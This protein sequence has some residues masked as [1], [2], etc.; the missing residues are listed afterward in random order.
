MVGTYQFLLKIQERSYNHIKQRSY[1]TNKKIIGY[2][3]WDNR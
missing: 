3:V 2:N 1:S